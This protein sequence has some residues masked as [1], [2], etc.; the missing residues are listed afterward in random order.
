[1]ADALAF[2]DFSG[3]VGYPKTPIPRR[4]THRAITPITT[5]R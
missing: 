3:R 2:Q 5:I 1:M 4:E